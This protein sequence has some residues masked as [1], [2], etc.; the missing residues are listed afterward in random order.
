MLFKHFSVFNPH[1]QFDFF[2]LIKS[3]KKGCSERKHLVEMF[4]F[5]NFL[6]CAGVTWGQLS[7]GN[8]WSISQCNNP[9]TGA[10]E[11]IAAFE[12]SYYEENVAELNLNF[13]LNSQEGW[14][15]FQKKNPRSRNSTVTI[16]MKFMTS[17]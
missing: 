3:A 4:K 9:E 13:V 8:P 6:V 15:N 7:S 14:Q 11:M 5:K 12:R 10:P 1:H 2:W 16:L 17:S